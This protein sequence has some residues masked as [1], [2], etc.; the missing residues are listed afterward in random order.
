[1]PPLRAS[2]D[3]SLSPARLRAGER[4]AFD[5]FYERNF[6]RVFTYALHRT[7]DRVTAEWVTEATLREAL[8]RLDELRGDEVP[9]AWMLGILVAKLAIACDPPAVVHLPRRGWRAR[10]E[11]AWRRLA[12][13]ARR[14]ARRAARQAGEEALR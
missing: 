7:E 8:E 4:T 6:R 12:R 5:A 10:V 2:P 11:D 3:V 13:S 9:A 1:M 14:P